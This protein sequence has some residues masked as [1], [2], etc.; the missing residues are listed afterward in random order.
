MEN[1]AANRWSAAANFNEVAGG[2]VRECP[3][4]KEAAQVFNDP[5]I[6]GERLQQDAGA[7]TGSQ[8]GTELSQN[9]LQVHW[10]L[11]FILQTLRGAGY[12]QLGHG[13]TWDGPHG[14]VVSMSRGK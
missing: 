13:E 3:T 10:Q 9:L 5:L 1:A 7:A 11:S 4:E 6:R 12:A 8:Q 14:T 2:E